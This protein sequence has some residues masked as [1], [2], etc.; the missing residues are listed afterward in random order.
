MNDT[1]HCKQVLVV[2]EL[3]D[4][5][6][7]TEKCKHTMCCR[8][9]R[10]QQDQTHTINTCSRWSQTQ[11]ARAK[12]LTYHVLQMVSDMGTVRSR[13]LSRISTLKMSTF[14]SSS[15]SFFIPFSEFSSRT[16]AAFDFLGGIIVKV[17]DYNEEKYFF[18]TNVPLSFT[19]NYCGFLC[20]LINRSHVEKLL[21]MW[22]R[23]IKQVLYGI[24]DIWAV[25][26][27]GW[28]TWH[29]CR[30]FQFSFYKIQ[31]IQ[32]ALQLYERVTMWKVNHVK[33]PVWNQELFHS[34]RSRLFASNILIL[35]IV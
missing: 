21:G 18:H 31:C 22:F 9:P 4:V 6:L 5:A 3:Y 10:T 30:S 27:V 23:K 20:G 13:L 32:D 34:T 12:M 15:I 11:H 24:K 29:I 16:R 33:L 25:C 8:W 26:Y 7:C 28:I 1:P 14:F 2:T 35:R 17:F 19:K